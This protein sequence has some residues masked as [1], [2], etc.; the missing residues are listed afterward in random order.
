MTVPTDG[1][2]TLDLFRE[3]AAAEDE[4]R[5]ER[6]RDR[7]AREHL[8]LAGRLAW[9]FS[10]SGEAHE[11]L[12]QVALLGLT[13]AIN[14]FDP[15]QGNDFLSFAIPTITGELRRYLRDRTWSVRVPRRLKELHTSISAARSELTAKL[16][17]APRPSEIAEHLGVGVEEVYEGLAAGQSRY[18]TSLDGMLEGDPH[19]RFGAADDN[20][21]Q[22]E[23]RELLRPVLD[24]LGERERKIIL[25][26]FVI[27]MSQTDIA[28]RVGVSQMQVSRLLTR[29]L[30]ELRGKL[31]DDTPLDL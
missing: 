22:A 10:N 23:L 4:A 15:E 30:N 5:K 2:D 8:D 29:T 17:R 14:R 26:R 20:L 27:G 11:D 21:A 31:G 9:K 18:G 16:S 1:Q 6:I 3:L 19:D 24:T 12:V 25:L 13:N 28:R 7:L